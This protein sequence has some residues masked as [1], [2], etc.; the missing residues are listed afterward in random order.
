M[1][2]IEKKL[3]TN[4]EAVIFDFDGVFTDNKVYLTEDGKEMVCCNRSD[5]WGIGNLH[6][7]K[8][9]MA[10]MSSEVNPVVLK[11]CEKLNKCN[12]SVCSLDF[13][14]VFDSAFSPISIWVSFTIGMF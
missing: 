9:K 5:G 6:N 3:P 14:N 2:N 12:A 10:V 4:L 7:A 11:R 13:H 1:N 8:I